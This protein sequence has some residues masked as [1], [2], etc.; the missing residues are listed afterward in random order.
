MPFKP[1]ASVG[2][3]ETSAIA[4][5]PKGVGVGPI[6]GIAKAVRR[7]SDAQRDAL[8]EAIVAG[9]QSSTIC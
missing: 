2:R 1:G 6:H 8:I 5:R 9:A 7:S 3:G 4:I